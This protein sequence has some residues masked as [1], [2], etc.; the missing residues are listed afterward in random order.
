M[1][2][3]GTVSSSSK[4]ADGIGGLPNGTLQNNDWFGF[5]GEI[6]DLDGDSI[7]DLMVGAVLGSKHGSFPLILPSITL[8]PSNK[9]CRFQQRSCLR[10]IV[11]C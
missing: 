11:E 6:G 4:I 7:P 8:D 9:Y 5:V 3:D 1:N 2:Q 10:A